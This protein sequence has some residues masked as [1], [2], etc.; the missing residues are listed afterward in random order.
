MSDWPIVHGREPPLIGPRGHGEGAAVRS[1]S[2]T[3]LRAEDAVSAFLGQLRHTPDDYQVVLLRESH[4]EQLYYIFDVGSLRAALSKAPPDARVMDVLNLHEYQATPAVD[5]DDATA[6]SI[7][8]PLLLGR[9]VVGV[10]A[11]DLPPPT[12]GHSTDGF[13]KRPD[14]STG[15][16][17]NSGLTRWRRREWEKPALDGAVAAERRRLGG[18]P[19]RVAD[20]GIPA[21]PGPTGATRSS[22]AVFRAFPS[23][24]APSKIEAGQQFTVSVGFSAEQTALLA[25]GPPVLIPRPGRELVFIVQLAG[26]GF[27]YPRGVRGELRVD[28]DQPFKSTVDL[29]AVAQATVSAARR[30]IE[31]SYEYE[32][33]VVGRTW[34]EVT[35]VAQGQPVPAE[36]AD[37]PTGNAGGLTQAEEADAH[38]T[39]D[40]RH[41]EGDPELEWVFHCRYTDV[42]RPMNRITTR[43]DT[44]SARAFA[45]QLMAQLPAVRDSRLLAATIK[46]MG[47]EIADR[48][49]IELWRLMQAVWRKA[50]DA[51]EAPTLLINTSEAWIPWELARLDEDHFT[52]HSL[53]PADGEGAALGL[54]WQV[55]RWVPPMRRL[56]DGDLPASPP[57]REI[58]VSAMAVVIGDYSGADLTVPA[59]PS[60]VAEGRAIALRYSAMPVTV[61]ADDVARLMSNEL[62]RNGGPYRPNVVH[63]AAHGQVDPNYPEYSGV[64]LTQAGSRLDALAVRGFRLVREAKPFVFLNACEVGT[65]GTVLSEYGG[66]AGAF[67]GDGARGFIAP[68]WKV[69]DD[70]AAQLALDFYRHTFDEGMTVGRAMQALRHDLA[71]SEEATGMAYVF[72]GN[73]ALVLRRT[74]H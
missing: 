14:R 28:R 21:T 52:D 24:R 55:G 71:D 63:F 22:G 70:V 73:P 13:N 57:V 16:R 11:V 60:A 29:V 54:L 58:N 59:L 19:S 7:G 62:E 35:V 40:I 6:A 36:Q 31:V 15:A 10:L 46:G 72:Y 49:P 47:R 44:G 5:I 64:L 26:F 74:R 18:S 61:S 48:M 2:T 33:N 69:N 53:L 9:D 17:R 20:E 23:V 39:V 65:A 41:R 27:T 1:A 3:V 45:V 4:A 32:G 50:V 12:R 34:A 37:A 8:S 68:L 38:L 42:E 25:G 67:L 66:L 30:L 56:V 51:D 43:L